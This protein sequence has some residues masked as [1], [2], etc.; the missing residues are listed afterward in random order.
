MRY[1][2]RKGGQDMPNHI[3]EENK[4]R[5][6]AKHTYMAIAMIGYIKAIA[7][8]APPKLLEGVRKGAVQFFTSA[9]RIMD[10]LDG[11]GGFLSEE[12]G[13]LCLVTDTLIRAE[14]LP[15][16]FPRNDR[17]DLV[18]SFV[19]FLESIKTPRSLSEEEKQTAIKLMRALR[20]LYE[21]GSQEQYA[22]FMDESC[23]HWHHTR[24]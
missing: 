18:R 8:G 15:S 10:N 3:L 7:E 6:A 13:V 20:V 17:R 16:D 23:G 19:T 22:N 5:G 4:M 24:F 11:P 14:L 2:E 1:A 21:A 9:L 12:L